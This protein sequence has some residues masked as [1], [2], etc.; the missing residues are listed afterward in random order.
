MKDVKKILAELSKEMQRG[1]DFDIDARQ[2]L[3]QLHQDAVRIEKS[4]DSHIQP[5]LDRLSE[6]E[7]KFASNHPGLERAARELADALAKMGI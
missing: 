6:F 4:G 1:E 2:V 5:M 3:D 7:S